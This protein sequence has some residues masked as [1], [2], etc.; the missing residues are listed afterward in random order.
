MLE[1]AKFGD[2]SGGSDRTEMIPRF[3]YVFNS[4]KKTSSLNSDAEKPLPNWDKHSFIL[5]VEVS[6]L[7]LD[8]SR[9]WD[10]VVY[11]SQKMILQLDT[12]YSTKLTIVSFW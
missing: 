1:D 3:T 2:S 6:H 4:N 8:D 12:K 11:N 9:Q 5:L 10:M 7:T